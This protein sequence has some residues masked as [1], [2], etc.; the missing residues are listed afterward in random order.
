M[1]DTQSAVDAATVIFAHSILDDVASEC[2]RISVHA[3]PNAWAAAIKKRQVSIE[4]IENR[5]YEQIR[6]EHLGKYVS[7]LTR[8]SLVKR[9][10]LLNQRCR[11]VPPF[12]VRGKKYDYATARIKDLDILR[13]AIIHRVTIFFGQQQ[14]PSLDTDLN[15]FYATAVS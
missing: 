11:P 9:L 6:D 15:Y 4:D 2:C 8:E 7:K 5:T 10:D 12:Y 14:M 13:Q 1:T 3:D